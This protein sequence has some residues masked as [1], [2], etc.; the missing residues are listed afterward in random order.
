MDGFEHV[1][2]LSFADVDFL[3]PALSPRAR[4]RLP[5]AFTPAQANAVRSFIDA[6]PQSVASVVVHCE[7]GY[8]RS[9][10]IA[11]AL[12]QLYGYHAELDKLGQANPSVLRLMMT[13]SLQ[14]RKRKR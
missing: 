1:L 3:S 11:L 9:C 10:A 7:G 5:A 6:L 2:R 14:G 12:H 8:S 13:E 4:A